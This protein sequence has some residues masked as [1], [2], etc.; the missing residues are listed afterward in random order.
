M[1]RWVTRS[2]L[3]Q[4]VNQAYLNQEK[5]KF[6]C[7]KSDCDFCQ[8]TSQYEEELRDKKVNTAN[9]HIQNWFIIYFLKDNDKIAIFPVKKRR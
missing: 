2:C 6:F 4:M 3:K 1:D 7:S 8:K 5:K 9:S